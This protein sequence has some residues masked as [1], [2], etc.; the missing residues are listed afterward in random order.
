MEE[1]Q[2]SED[3]I[4]TLLKSDDTEKKCEAIEQ[5]MYIDQLDDITAETLCATITDSNNSVRNAATLTLTLNN[6][7]N[8]PKY[9]VNYISSS[10][11]S[12]RNLAGEI[13]IK[14]GEPAVDSLIEK[15]KNTQ[16]EDDQKFVIDVLGLIGVE[17]PGYLI[18]DSLKN[19]KDDN[20]ILSCIEALGNIKSEAAV[21]YLIEYYDLNELFQPMVIEA[22]GKIGSWKALDFIK[23]KYNAEDELTKFAIVESLGEI[24]N[25]ETFYFLLEELSNAQGPILWQFVSSLYKLKE[26]FNLDLPFDERLKHSI[27]NTITE[28]DSEFRRIACRLVTAFDDK[29]II[30]ACLNVYGEDPEFDDIIKPKFYDN[31]NLIYKEISEKLTNEAPNLLSLLYLMQELLQYNNLNNGLSLSDLEKRKILDGLTLHVDNFDEEVRKTVME[32]IFSLDRDTA[33]LFVDTFV[34]DNSLWN[35]LKLVELLE[36]IE[37]SKVTAALEKLE[38]D[39]E[40]MISERVKYMLSQKTPTD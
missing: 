37:L 25:E 39:P 21:D 14:I 1:L 30:V 11:I 33:L 15:L 20:V 17:K 32:N 5:M 19:S 9:L 27:L 6:S 13:L 16:N 38:D 2:K 10:E 3:S 28:A 40:E 22:I 26:K 7:R 4:V 35:R 34:E 36:N 29:D 8:I 31:S 24:G 23:E 12:I 18:I